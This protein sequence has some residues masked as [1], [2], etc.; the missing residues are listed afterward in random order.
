MDA[1]LTDFRCLCY[2]AQTMSLASNQ[3]NKDPKKVGFNIT[4]AIVAGQVGCFTTLIII[5]ALIAGIWLDNQFGSKPMFTI[6]FVVASVPITLF[7]MFWIVRKATSR[8]I[9]PDSQNSH[10]PHKEERT[11]E[12]PPP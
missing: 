9:K 1:L 10:S 7:V 2:N 4:M 8:M 11:S 5:V 12:R 3:T 6:G